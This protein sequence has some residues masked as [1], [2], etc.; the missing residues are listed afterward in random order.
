MEHIKAIFFKRHVWRFGEYFQ[1]LDDKKWKDR[2]YPM[3]NITDLNGFL[4]C[5]CCV[6]PFCVVKAAIMSA[7]H[8]LMLLPVLLV[9]SALLLPYHMV[10]L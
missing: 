9:T 8:L 7:I 10:M 6:P 3:R 2:K 5:L 4:C 1:V